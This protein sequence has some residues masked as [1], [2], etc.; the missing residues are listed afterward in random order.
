VTDRL[1]DKIALSTW[2]VSSAV[3]TRDKN[4]V[5]LFKAATPTHS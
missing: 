5:T 2:R 1:T 4:A 3:L